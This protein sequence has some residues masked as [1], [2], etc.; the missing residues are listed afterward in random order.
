[1]PNAKEM[2]EELRKLRKESAVNKPVSKMRMT[3]VTAEIERLK[4][5]RETTA[6]VASTPA[7][8]TAKAMEPKISDLKKSKEAEFPT[9]PA[10][11]K[12]KA[13]KKAVVVG[14]SGAI[15]ET[16]TKPS[17]KKSKLEKLMAMLESD[18]E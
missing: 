16:T 13:G 6:P 2:R 14:G 9:A 10:E 12:K 5:M 3:D 1:M 11:P 7:H 17:G 15:G 8:K 18:S 4:N